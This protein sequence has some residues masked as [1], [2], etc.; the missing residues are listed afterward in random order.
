ML[1][2]N[3]ETFQK[4]EQ[5]RQIEEQMLTLSIEYN[6]MWSKGAEMEKKYDEE[7]IQLKFASSQIEDLNAKVA[8]LERQMEE[9][10][11]RYREQSNF[12]KEKYTEL[13]HLAKE[14]ETTIKDQSKVI[15]QLK[16]NLLLEAQQV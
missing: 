7:A 12:S 4:G 3:H 14:G 16:A 6:Q 1:K 8:Q 9:E 5:Y 10:K 15:D 11:R 2:L 13:E